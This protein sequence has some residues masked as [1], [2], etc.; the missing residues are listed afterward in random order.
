M[1][2]INTAP[3]LLELE[4]YNQV[5]DRL[6]TAVPGDY[7]VVIVSNS[8][9]S[10]FAPLP[11]TGR[12]K[13]VF[14]FSDEKNRLPDYAGDEDVIVVFKQYA[15]FTPHPK[16]CPIPMPYMAGF[17]SVNVPFS[18]RKRNFFFRGHCNGS[19][20]QELKKITET[21]LFPDSVIE[22]TDTFGGG[23]KTS[24]A[25][26]LGTSKFAICPTGNNAETFR[27]VE[28]A[29]SG[30]IVVSNHQGAHWYNADVPFIYVNDWVELGLLFDSLISAPDVCAKLSK[31]TLDY[32]N[33][34]LSVEAVSRVCINVLKHELSRTHEYYC[35]Q[36]TLN[37]N[38]L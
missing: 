38:P 3:N 31:D 19:S 13:A 27:H 18:E 21:A 20:R 23:D 34:F 16:L 33:K 28:A 12:K 17:K 25:Q 24:Y 37:Q 7:D 8:P 5:I 9:D 35:P 26:M 14:S 30:C 11:K 36:I 29:M 6:I 10:P 2:I 15:P 22:F 32:Y 1:Q 4:F